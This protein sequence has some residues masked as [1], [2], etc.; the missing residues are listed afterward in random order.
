MDRDFEQ[1]LKRFEDERAP[2]S[3]AIL[4]GLND[5]NR[6][7]RETFRAAWSRLGA[8]RRREVI[9]GLIDLAEQNIDVNFGAVMRVALDDQ[10]E[11]IRV[12]AVRGLWEDE[13][14]DLIGPLMRLL[15]TDPSEDVRE[16]A[17]SALGQFV[18]QGELGTLGDSQAFAVEEALLRAY[19]DPAESVEVRRKALQ[20]LSFSSDEAMRDLIEE[21]FKDADNRMVMSAIFAMGRSADPRWERT[22]RRELRRA[23]PEIRFEAARALGELEAAEAVYELG[24]M[25]QTDADEQVREMCIHALGQIGG[26]EAQRILETMAETEENET[27]Q[28]AIAEALDELSFIEDIAEPPT[29]FGL[30]GDFEDEDEDEDDED[31][32]DDENDENNGRLN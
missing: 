28:E 10:D 6:E 11:R 20:S 18:L 25:A 27:L 7:E 12:Q 15:A 2:V 22:V 26:K 16:E 17:A 14:P 31:G 8:A 5:L 21:A 19:N 30:D 1:S 9:D 23:S 32:G 29:L 13:S 4:Y 24:E 3:Q